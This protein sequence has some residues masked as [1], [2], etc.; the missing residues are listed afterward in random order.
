MQRRKK[1]ETYDDD[2][3][4]TPDS[5]DP[6]SQWVAANHGGVDHLAAEGRAGE[7][8]RRILV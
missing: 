8:A 3:W 6:A 2:D 5:S 7:R 1:I 4:L